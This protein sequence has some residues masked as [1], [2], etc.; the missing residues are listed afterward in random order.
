VKIVTYK[1]AEKVLKKLLSFSKEPNL[2]FEFNQIIKDSLKRISGDKLETDLDFLTKEGLIG[3]ISINSYQAIYVTSH[4]YTYFD[5]K[6]SLDKGVHLTELRVHV[7]YPSIVA[8]ITFWLGF[9]LGHM[10]K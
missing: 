1:R 7:L 9:F 2:A 3:S 10:T 4:G 5:E 8:F 6:H